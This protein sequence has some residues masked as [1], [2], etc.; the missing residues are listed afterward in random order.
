MR[1]KWEKV[2]LGETYADRELDAAFR[3]VAAPDFKARCLP[4]CSVSREVGNCYTASV[5]AGLVSVVA[6]NGSSLE[7]DGG[8]RVL[9]FSYGSG[10]VATAYSF[11]ARPSMSEGFSLGAMKEALGIEERLKG[12]LQRTPEQFAQAM[13]LREQRYGKAGYRPTGD[14]GDLFPGTFY[15]AEVNDKYHRR[16]AR[17]P[18]ATPAPRS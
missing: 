5:F 11:K 17:T 15:L 4:A 10:F 16:Y 1:D 8:A 12:R 14:A 9:M 7:A 6:A 18:P 13:D 2:E 3:K